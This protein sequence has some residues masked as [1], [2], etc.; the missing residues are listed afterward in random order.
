MNKLFRKLYNILN[1]NRSNLRDNEDVIQ[2]DF[3][4]ALLMSY[5]DIPVIFKKMLSEFLIDDEKETRLFATNWI[6]IKDKKKNKILK[7]FWKIRQ[8]YAKKVNQ[9]LRISDAETFGG[10]CDFSNGTRPEINLTLGLLKYQ[11]NDIINGVMCHELG[12]VI[13][14]AWPKRILLWML[15][16]NG[17]FSVMSV[18]A[19]FYLKDVSF[20]LSR[21][22]LLI[23]V[24]ACV[25][26]TRLLY[27][28]PR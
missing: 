8:P 15:A 14:N 5:L 6:G 17:A 22:F 25:K 23:L 10:Y 3:D 18:C 7:N 24:L 21:L 2:Y 26:T 4:F 27:S 28:T 16:L 20:T 12:H 9:H 19:F 13:E 11:R 1:R